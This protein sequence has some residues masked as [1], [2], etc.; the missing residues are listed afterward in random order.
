VRR[1]A[2]ISADPGVP[3][4]GRKGASVHV[5]EVIRALRRQ[6]VDVILFTASLG[7]EAP[8]DLSDLHVI[9]LPDVAGADSAQRERNALGQN[10]VLAR[11]LEEHGPFDALYERHSLWSFAGLEWARCGGVPALLEVNA[12]LLLEQAKYRS[13]HDADSARDAVARA[14]AAADAILAVS[15]QVADHLRSF[16]DGLAN[17]IHIVPNGVDPSKFFRDREPR[18]TPFTIGFVG[19][20]KPWHGVDLLLRAFARVHGAHS[21]V[22][23][24]IV[25]DGPERETLES[26]VR[27]LGL[28]SAVEFTGA[29]DPADVPQHLARMDVAVAPYPDLSD[30]YFSPLKMYEYMAAECAIVASAIGQITDVL[31]DGENALLY[32][33]GDID[34]LAQAIER[35][36]GDAP[37]RRRLTAAARHAVLESHTWDA[38]A[39]RILELV[40]DAS[41]RSQSREARKLRM[42]H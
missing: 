6:G 11:L 32:P 18:D 27:D 13:L 7:G 39:Q 37:L 26:M 23:L 20:L 12:P 4:F 36:R 22:R 33:P 34:A 9:L 31:E 41:R 21:D 5:Q 25:G 29:V 2:Y 28:H 3:V 38:V 14:Y 16:D 10:P 30:F 35:L 8:A 17:K 19:T 1:L 24:L 42:V 15:E 40:D